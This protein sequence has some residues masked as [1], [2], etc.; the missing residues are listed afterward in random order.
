MALLGGNTYI[1]SKSAVSLEPTRGRYGRRPARATSY[2]VRS[3]PE[4]TSSIL[5]IEDEPEIRGV[6]AAGLELRGFAVRHADNGLVGLRT[7]ARV[8]PDV[9]ILDLGLPDISGIEVLESVRAWSSVPVIV[10]SI[11]S[12]EEQKVHLLKLGADDYVVKPFGIDE[13]AAR[14]KA[15]LRRYHRRADKN[16]IVR[17]GP[18]VV[19]LISRSAAFSGEQ[20]VLTKKEYRLL[21]LLASHLGL[22]VTHQQL[23]QEIWDEPSGESLHY[24]RTLMRFL[25]RKIE[26]DPKQPKFLLT[27]S[28][29]G[30]RL[31]KHKETMPCSPLVTSLVRLTGCARGRPD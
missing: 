1:A 14:C 17:T 19:D 28:G 23:I 8:H 31:E 24:L 25:R 27:E 22:V 20:I 12:D 2:L 30:Y 11:D 18:L 15:A 6:V 21:H 4:P 26:L 16:P 7:A 29:V 5:V 10:L 3:M 9:I 13:L